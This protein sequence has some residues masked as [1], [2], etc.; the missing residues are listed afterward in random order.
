MIKL[1]RTLPLVLASAAFAVTLVAGGT[2]ADAQYYKGKTITVLVGA[3]PSSGA[4]IMARIMSKNLK[5]N[6]PGDPNVIV[7]N[8]PGGGGSKAQNFLY[9]KAKKDGTI[10]YYGFW[11]GLAQV[12]G[13]PGLRFKYENFEPVGGLKLAGVLIWGRKDAVPAGG[14]SA[15]IGKDKAFRIGTI[16]IQNGR[17]LMALLG[18]E[19]LKANFTFIGGYRGNGKVRQAVAA[20]ELQ[21]SVDAIHIYLPIVTKVMKG[22]NMGIYHVPL[23]DQAGNVSDNPI[24]TKY[25]PN[26]VDVHKKMHGS[27][28]SGIAWEAFKQSVVLTQSMQHMIMGPPGLNEEAASAL[29]AAMKKAMASEQFAKDMKNQVLFVPEYVDRATAKKVLAGPSKTSAELKQYYKDFIAKHSQ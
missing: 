9:E 2:S 20:G 25:A 11:N 8:L 16:G 23:I 26:I 14:S 27:A 3:G 6:L 29:E 13:A 5:A 1:S 12:V 10:V 4:T 21:G 18:L 28:P 7:K 15:D 22:L 24:L 17:S 19:A